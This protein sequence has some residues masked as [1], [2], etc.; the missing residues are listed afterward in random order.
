M[1]QRRKLRNVVFLFLSTRSPPTRSSLVIWSSNPLDSQISRI[2]NPFQSKSRWQ[3]K[4]NHNP[5]PTGRL[6]DAHGRL[7]RRSYVSIRTISSNVE[8]YDTTSERYY[9]WWCIG[10]WLEFERTN[11][12]LTRALA[13]ARCRYDRGPLY[14]IHLILTGID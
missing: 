10:H 8:E 6:G 13:R 9:R 3:R 1:A 14:T 12:S 2:R 5:Q 11:L 4:Y 7:K